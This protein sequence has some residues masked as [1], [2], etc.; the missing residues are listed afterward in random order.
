MTLKE[1]TAVLIENGELYLYDEF[2]GVV[3]KLVKT[4]KGVVEKFLKW[5]GRS[6]KKV[7]HSNETALDIY[8]DSAS[9]RVTKDFYEKY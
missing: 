5:K 9:K 4:D 1:K 8:I 3:L 6:E 7:E 2:L